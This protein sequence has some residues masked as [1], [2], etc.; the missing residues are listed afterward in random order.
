M[1]DENKP[2][3]D[4]VEPVNEIEIENDSEMITE[5]VEFEGENV[6][7]AEIVS[8]DDS[9]FL[10][11]ATIKE[12]NV[13]FHGLMPEHELEAIKMHQDGVP[14]GEIAEHFGMAKSDIVYTNKS[15]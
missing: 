6:N 14:L 5:I 4:F 2:F 7:L 15:R 11:D 8:D 10:T 13:K 3:G 12:I 1:K 9:I